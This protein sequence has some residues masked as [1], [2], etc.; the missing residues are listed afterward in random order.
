MADGAG[1]KARMMEINPKSDRMADR[2]MPMPA[3]HL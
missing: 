2:R 1:I 3:A